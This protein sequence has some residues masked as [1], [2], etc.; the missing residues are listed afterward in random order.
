MRIVDQG[1]VYAPPESPVHDRVAAFTSLFIDHR[2]LQV[3]GFQLGS[4]KHAVDASLRLC[5]RAPG[6]RTFTT[7]VER[8]PTTFAGRPGSL[9]GAELVE[10]EPGRWVLATTW[11]D[12]SD[13]A[14]PLFDP[15]TE[16]LLRSRQL[17]CEST[18]RGEHWSDW[19]EIPTGDLK[20]CALTGPQLRFAGGRVAL[21]LESF[22]EYDDPTPA[23][24]GAWLLLS[25]DG[26]R[27]FPRRELLAQDPH[28]QVYYWD[29]RLCLTA[30]GRGYVALFWTHDR[31]S[32]RDL[33]VHLLRGEPGVPVSTPPVDTGITGQI[34]AP[35]ELRD[36]RLLM[37]VVDR[38]RPP[39]MTLWESRDAGRSWPGDRKVV[40]YNHDE[41]AQLSQGA[42]N[43]DFADYWEDMR[44]WTF[45]HPALRQL[46]T[47]EVLA[48]W[49]A[50][51]PGRMGIR[52]AEIS[53]T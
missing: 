20:G 33:T 38:N 12:R 48:V 26:G 17:L 27:S 37:F 39:T 44:K 50:G 35:L 3:V 16:G 5:R 10:P 21:A 19:R 40:V 11:F 51:E 7:L 36:G 49:Y 25:D 6:E 31:A 47:G 24:H 28:H 34:A 13:P 30:D 29:Q 14:R 9:A 22:K 53:V 4:A 43:I 45:G 1:I 2:G 15:E 42:E 18:D 41:Q 52:W 32:Q 46:P 8:F 23:R